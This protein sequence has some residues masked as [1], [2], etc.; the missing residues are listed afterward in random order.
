MMLIEYSVLKYH[1][2]I[3]LQRNFGEPNGENF[4]EASR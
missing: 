2:L 4:I 1:K 3:E